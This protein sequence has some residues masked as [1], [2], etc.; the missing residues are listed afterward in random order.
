LTTRL[1]SVDLLRGVVMVIM[2]L[3]HVRDFFS[4]APYDPLDLAR[5]DP[6]LFLT[7]WITH[8]C[9][10]VFVFLAGSSAYL[11]LS[12]GRT[13][14]GLARFL[15][16]RGVLLVLL[17]LT[18]VRF[19]WLFN[20]DYRFLFVQVIWAL[21]WSMI[22][23]AALVFLPTWAV[24]AF[25]I[26]MIA[27]HNLLDSIG[28]D[29]FGSLGWLWTILHNPGIM[30]LP[31]GRYIVVYP[32]I[33]W[34]GVIALGYGIGPILVREQSER[35]RWL[36]GIGITMTLAFVVLRAINQYGDPQPWSQQSDALFTVF[37]FINL[38][39]YPPSLLFLL[40]T[41]GPSLIMLALLDSKIGPLGRPFVIFGRVPLFYYLLHLPLIHLIAVGIAYIRF[42]QASWL[43]DNA[44]GVPSQY[45]YDLPVVYLVWLTVIV[46]LFPVCRWYAGVKQ[47][48]PDTW[49][50]Y[51]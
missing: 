30:P 34:L 16:I 13:K 24:A 50:R 2:A 48:R 38:T 3:D 21:G 18:V 33:P 39:K 40:M 41:L 4:N 44:M 14:A 37:S 45:G 17:E 8:F 51:L 27:G 32:L 42:G 20:L 22:V 9:A 28:P 11:S 36:I 5:T 15:L 46:V 31:G 10:P 43:L 25:G 7:R 35:R 29:R 19:G 23:L 1:D 6:A 12:R 26:V 47:R 49:L